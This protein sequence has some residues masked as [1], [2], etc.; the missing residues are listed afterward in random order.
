MVSASDVP[1]CGGVADLSSVLV[2]GAFMEYTVARCVFNSS[3]LKDIEF[4][5]SLYYNKLEYARFSSSV[6][7]YVGYTEFGVKNAERWN[8]DPSEITTRKNEK[9]RYC[10]NNVGNDYYKALTKSGEC[11]CLISS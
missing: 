10:L 1:G 11:L 5:L 8:S 6:G 3:E 2:P 4:I 9:E 7:K